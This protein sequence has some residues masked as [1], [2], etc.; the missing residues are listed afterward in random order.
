MTDVEAAEPGHAEGVEEGHCGRPYTA[1]DLGVLC[2][3]FLGGVLGIGV[4]VVIVVVEEE[5]CRSCLDL[6]LEMLK[7]VGMGMRGLA[8]AGVLCHVPAASILSKRHVHQE[9]P[10]QTATATL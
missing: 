9:E 7:G 3:F 5:G 2:I 1:V 10:P 6:R 4:V 8:V